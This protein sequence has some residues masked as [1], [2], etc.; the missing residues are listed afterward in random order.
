MGCRTNPSLRL[1]LI[2]YDARW[3]TVQGRY[4]CR[5]A[6]D[7]R[8]GRVIAGKDIKSRAVIR[9]GYVNQQKAEDALHTGIL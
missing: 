1:N 7:K 4:A 6:E 3:R 2:P 8:W 5:A 9:M